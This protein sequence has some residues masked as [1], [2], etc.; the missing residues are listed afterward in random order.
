MTNS[1]VLI[2][3]TS[4]SPLATELAR[5]GQSLVKL[6]KKFQKLAASQTVPAVKV[7]SKT[8]PEMFTKEFIKTVRQ[9][10]RDFKKGNFTNYS[11]FRKTLNLK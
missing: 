7:N 2:D 3:S 8:D 5:I 10:R 1:Q 11:D 9:S 4:I 6:S